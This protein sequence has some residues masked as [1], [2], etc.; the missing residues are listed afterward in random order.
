MTGR[1]QL[2][3]TAPAIREKAIHWIRHVPEGTRVEFKAPQR[4]PEQN[5]RMW[6]ML[7]DVASQLVWHGE[8][9]STNDWKIVFLDGLK[10]E[11]RTVRN[12]DGTGFVALG[13][14]SSDLSKSEMADLITLIMMFGDKHGVVWSDPKEKALRELDRREPA[15]EVAA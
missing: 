8:K 6:A 5:D 15:A 1:A 3:L 4:T 10:R 14:S 2:V 11:L 13:R 7:T 9:L 12:I